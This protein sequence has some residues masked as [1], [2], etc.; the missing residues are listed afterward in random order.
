MVDW[1]DQSWADKWIKVWGLTAIV[2]GHPD[3]PGLAGVASEGVGCVGTCLL[4]VLTLQSTYIELNQS[5][6]HSPPPLLS[7]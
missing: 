6:L 1:L 3:A 7:L 5:H 4:D 2:R